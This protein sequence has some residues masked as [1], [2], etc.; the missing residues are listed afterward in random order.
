MLIAAAI[1]PF[2]V[3][4]FLWLVRPMLKSLYIK[5]DDGKLKRLLFFHW[6]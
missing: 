1:T 5:M 2:Y 6:N 3:A 4:G